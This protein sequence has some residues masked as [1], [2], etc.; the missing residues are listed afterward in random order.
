MC[1]GRTGDGDGD[2][3]RR[4][5]SVGRDVPA[6]WT[7][8]RDDGDVPVTFDWRRVRRW[9][10]TDPVADQATC[11]AGEVTVPTVVLATGPAGVTYVARSAGAV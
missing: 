4:P 6:G 8:T 1:R 2:A 10:P 9:L 7:E 3:R 11:T 5:R